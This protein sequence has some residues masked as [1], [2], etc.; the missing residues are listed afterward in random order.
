MN[1]RFKNSLIV[2]VMSGL[3]VVGFSNAT[4]QSYLDGSAKARGDYG[5]MS[6]SQSVP[7]YRVT[8][9]SQQRSFSYQPVPTPT[10][11]QPSQPSGDCG[12]GNA[13]SGKAGASNQATAPQGGVAQRGTQTY[14]A[15]SYEPGMS[16]GTLRSRSNSTP[17]YLLPKT[18]SR[19]L[20]GG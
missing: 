7:S 8:A 2:T 5:Q 10:T 6:R 3:S 4:A 16:S 9:P 20:G 12:C 11:D 19:R 1:A 15:Y 17:L 18:D 14:R 13:D